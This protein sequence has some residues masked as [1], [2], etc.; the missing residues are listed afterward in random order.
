[1]VW[2]GALAA[3]T[4]AGGSAAV[5]YLGLVTGALPLDVGIGRRTRPL[6]PQTV[7]IAAPREVVF[8]LITQPYVGRATRAMREKVQVLERGSDMVLAAHHTPVAGGR[9]TATTVETVKFTRPERVDFRLVRGPVPA[10]TELFALTEHGSGTRL[11]YEGELAT[12]LWRAGQWWG[13][14]VAPRWEATVAASLAAVRQ[15]AERRAALP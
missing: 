7:D 15:E 2:I 13:G 12:D 6:G 5:G 14:L 10:V 8:D 3:V 1:M 9:L 11:V 4:V